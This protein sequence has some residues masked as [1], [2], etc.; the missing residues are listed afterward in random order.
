MAQERAWKEKAG[1]KT[2]CP[3]FSGRQAGILGEQKNGMGRSG[4]TF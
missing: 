2:A 1:I 4:Q 3:N